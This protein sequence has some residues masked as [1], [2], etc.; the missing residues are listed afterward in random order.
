MDTIWFAS[1]ILFTALMYYLNCII[2]LRKK[3]T[4]KQTVQASILAEAKRSN[5]KQFHFSDSSLG[6]QF[7]HPWQPGKWQS[8]LTVWCLVHRVLT[9]LIPA[10][11]DE[12]LIPTNP[13]S[14]LFIFFEGNSH[15][16]K[17]CEKAKPAVTVS[18]TNM[19]LAKY[20]AGCSWNWNFKL[21]Q[22]WL[23]V[24]CSLSIFLVQHVSECILCVCLLLY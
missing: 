3:E 23:I 7:P 10:V 2:S 24:E 8:A 20:R 21:S 19:H 18:N 12:L 16:K 17:T 9:R 6:W 14:D 4:F 15:F 5:C 11:S 13:P 22:R 1:L